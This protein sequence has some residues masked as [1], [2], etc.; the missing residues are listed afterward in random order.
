MV[1]SGKTHRS[2]LLVGVC[3]VVSVAGGRPALSET[4]FGQRVEPFEGVIISERP[5]VSTSPQALPVGRFQVEGGILFTTD[6]SPGVDVDIITA[7]LALLRYGIAQDI[8]VQIGWSGITE[9]EVNGFDETGTGDVIL[10]A[11]MQ[12]TEQV[13]NTPTMGVIGSLSLPVGDDTGSD[14]VDPSVG[15]LWNYAFLEGLGLFG[16]ATVAGASQGNDRFFQF[17][18]A[19]GLGTA[20]TD[21]I[22]VFGEYAAQFNANRQDSH[23]LDFGLTYLLTDNLQLDLNAGAGV[24]GAAPDGFFGG[25]VAY[26]W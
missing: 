19:V 12:L 3:A 23:L 10:S 20:I 1:W 25:G 11:K 21:R 22:G 18:N 13:G 4:L 8:E 16:T 14:N 17:S 26:R 6:D 2:G 15:F 24:G 9:V 7:P 5:S